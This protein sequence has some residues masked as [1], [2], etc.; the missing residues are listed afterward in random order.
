[1]EAKTRSFNPEHF[2]YGMLVLSKA[3]Q[4]CERRFYLNQASQIAL[5]AKW[6]S[7][8]MKTEVELLSSLGRITSALFLNFDRAAGNQPK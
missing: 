3:S 2:K 4:G 1:M 6:I 5:V 7:S 8:T